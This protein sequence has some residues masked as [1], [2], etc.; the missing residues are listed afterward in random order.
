[1][2]NVHTFADHFGTPTEVYAVIVILALVVWSVIW[3]IVR[4]LLESVLETLYPVEDSDRLR[5]AHAS[6]AGSDGAAADA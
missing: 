5:K 6:L 3:T 4:G 2:E 1:M